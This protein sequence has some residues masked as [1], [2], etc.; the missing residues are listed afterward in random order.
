M[1]ESTGAASGKMLSQAQIDATARLLTQ[2]IDI[3]RLQLRR[4]REDMNAINKTS[5][6][7]NGD[8]IREARTSL[9]ADVHYMLISLHHVEQLLSRLKKLLPHEAELAD[10]R[11]RYRQWLKK[12]NEFRDNI[13]H[14]DG[15]IAK[16]LLELAGIEGCSFALDGWRLEIGP[17]QEQTAEAFFN[18]VSNA[19]AKIS[20]RQKKI[21]SLITRGGFGAS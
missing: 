9:F 11:N 20:D 5:S 12:C 21:R 14:L 13:E 7:G 18:D 2:T 15:R 4:I 8:D 19:W 16:N 10:I 3:A 6:S 1:T 17:S